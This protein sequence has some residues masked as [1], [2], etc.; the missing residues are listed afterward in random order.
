[1]RTLAASRPHTTVTTLDKEAGMK[2]FI[3]ALM[4][5]GTPFFTRWIIQYCEHSLNGYLL[6]FGIIIGT[7]IT[8]FFGF[9]L[10]LYAVAEVVERN[11]ERNEH[12]AHN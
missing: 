11:K 9:C 3:A 2:F 4:T 1:M 5:F 8:M 12:N 10:G 7:A 6:A